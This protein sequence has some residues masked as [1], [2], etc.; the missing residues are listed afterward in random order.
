[1][2][3]KRHKYNYSLEK[4]LPSFQTLYKYFLRDLFIR[5]TIQSRDHL[6]V[7]RS[8]RIISDTVS[9]VIRYMTIFDSFF[10]VFEKPKKLVFFYLTWC[11]QT[12]K[13]PSFES[14]SYGPLQNDL[15]L[16]KKSFL[17]MPK[18]M[19]DS[20]NIFMSNLDGHLK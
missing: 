8:N 12:K 5:H 17:M 16:I 18:M 11:K 3:F 2:V 15:F 20:E 1:M 9:F 19:H 6:K 7:I 13:F 14:N 10:V 4:P